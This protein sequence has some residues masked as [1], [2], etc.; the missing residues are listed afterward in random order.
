MRV[1]RYLYCVL[2][3]VTQHKYLLLEYRALN[4][5]DNAW[6]TFIIIIR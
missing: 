3:V 4:N 1:E 5:I 2:R 6:Y